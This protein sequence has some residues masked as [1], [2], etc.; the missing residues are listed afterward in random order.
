LLACFPAA[1]P[2]APVHVHYDEMVR[3]LDYVWDSHT[4]ARRTW[5]V[6]LWQL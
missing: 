2:D 1:G 5:S 3:L 4:T 6:L